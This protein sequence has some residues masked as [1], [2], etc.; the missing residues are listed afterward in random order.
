MEEEEEDEEGGDFFADRVDLGLF[1]RDPV[2]D[3]FLF[4]EPLL[5]EELVAWCGC[6]LVKWV[7]QFRLHY[8]S[9]CALVGHGFL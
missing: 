5:Q 8:C 7:R 9:V 6:D 2:Q 1:E 3:Q 4:F